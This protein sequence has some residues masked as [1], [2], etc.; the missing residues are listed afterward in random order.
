MIARSARSML[1]CRHSPDHWWME[2]PPGDHQGIERWLISRVKCVSL[3]LVKGDIVQA[4]W[5]PALFA[6]GSPTTS[7]QSS[8]TR[9]TSTADAAAAI[10]A[11]ANRV[12]RDTRPR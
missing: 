10:V 9:T 8:S 6:S 2:I 12:R 11:M 3:M 1:C 7:S 5:G 4:I